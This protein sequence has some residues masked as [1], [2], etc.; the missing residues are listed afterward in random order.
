M[1]RYCVG[2]GILLNSV[3]PV[4]GGV[5]QYKWQQNGVLKCSFY[6]WKWTVSPENFRQNEYVFFSLHGNELMGA[7]QC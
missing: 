6:A 3:P 7:I 5:L 4:G 2:K 1:N